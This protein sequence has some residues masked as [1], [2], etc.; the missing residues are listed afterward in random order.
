MTKKEVKELSEKISSTPHSEL[1][2]LRNS[3]AVSDMHWRLKEAC[4]VDI[5]RK[6]NRVEHIGDALLEGS[7]LRSGEIG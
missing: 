1:E 3:V 4:I 7:E 5:D 6:L 2:A